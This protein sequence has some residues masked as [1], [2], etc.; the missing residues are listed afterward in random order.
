M[1]KGGAPDADSSARQSALSAM[2]APLGAATKQ[3]LSVPQVQE[4]AL[5]RAIYTYY[6]QRAGSLVQAAIRRGRLAD[7]RAGRARCSD[8]Q[9]PAYVYDHRDYSRPLD[10]EACCHGCNVK[11]GPG[12]LRADVVIEAIRRGLGL[13]ERSPRERRNHGRATRRLALEALRRIPHNVETKRG[14]R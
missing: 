1:R 12:A 9:H 14:A 10:V 11:R 6:R 4:R 2:R 3:G 13:R 7:L 5:G 8:C